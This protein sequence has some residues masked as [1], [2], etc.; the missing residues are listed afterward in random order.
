MDDGRPGSSQAGGAKSRG[1]GGDTAQDHGRDDDQCL[2]HRRLVGQRQVDP[3]IHAGRRQQAELAQR[4][5]GQHQRR[6]PGRQIDDA[7]IAP[8]H[9]VA[10]AGA[11]RL[12]ARLLG[13][14]ALG[15]ARRAV[16][17]VIGA[18]ALL[19]RED[20]L[21]ETLAEALDGALDAADIDEVAAEAE[22]H[23][24][25]RSPC[26]VARALSMAARIRLMALSRPLK[27]ASPT[28][29]WPILSSTMVG[30]AATPATVS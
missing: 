20:A 7:D 19:R 9:A 16:G 24:A 8:E 17:P 28:R 22:D 29:K 12:G 27:I 2:R 3:G 14:I 13:G 5:A 11:E 26:A 15:V 23:Q 25:L 21:E 10:K 1:G 18:P 30:M 4:A 6:P